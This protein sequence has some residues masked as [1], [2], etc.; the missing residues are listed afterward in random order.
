MTSAAEVRLKR[1]DAPM[2]VLNSTRVK[3][4]S[5]QDF[6]IPQSPSESPQLASCGTKWPLSTKPGLIG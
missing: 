6:R 5:S 4:V 1:Q 3:N 2:N